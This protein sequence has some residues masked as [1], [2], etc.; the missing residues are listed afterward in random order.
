MFAAACL[1]A[2]NS[3]DLPLAAESFAEDSASFVPQESNVPIRFAP[4]SVQN[5][6]EDYNQAG[7]ARRSPGTGSYSW[8]RLGIFCLAKYSIEGLTAVHNPTWSGI[9]RKADLNKYSI[10]KKNELG[11]LQFDDNTNK[12]KIVW[13]SD[14][15]DEFNFYPANDWFAYGFVAY[16]PHTENIVYTQGTIT[17]L[18]KVDGDDDVC[19]A[20][21]AAP[22]TPTPP[23]NDTYSAIYRKGFSRSYY[24]AI[25]GHD[26]GVDEWIYPRFEFTRMMARLVFYIHMKE[27]PKYNLHVEKVE[28]EDFPC[29]MK[30]GLASKTSGNMKLNLDSSPKKWFMRNYDD[31]NAQKVKMMACYKMDSLQIEENFPELSSPFGH[32]ELRE[33]N[34]ESISNQKNEDGT[35][36]YAL[37]TAWITIGG[38]III[39]PVYEGHSRSSLKIY[40]TLADDN[41][42][43][44]RNRSAIVVPPPTGGYK[45]GESYPV[46]IALSNPIPAPSDGEITDWEV[47]SAR[48]ITTNSEWEVLQ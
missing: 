28:M 17:A 15:K 1:T 10:W 5:V 43:T 19:Y 2:C 27:E 12:G 8:D 39:P 33:E 14:Y 20:M 22:K 26:S 4:V 36:K 13:G 42:N 45:T 37:S 18:I 44:Y 47:E 34:G 30:V 3:N 41:G 6:T 9:A 48:N 11:S 24:N 21:A 32:F 35:Y 31:L 29:I 25:S 38:G 40:V 23:T 7:I 46:P 16:Y